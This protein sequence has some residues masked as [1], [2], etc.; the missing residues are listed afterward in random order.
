M[1][2]HTWYKNL[3]YGYEDAGGELPGGSLPE[4][5]YAGVTDALGEAPKVEIIHPVDLGGEQWLL[6]VEGNAAYAVRFEAPE[7]P[8]LSSWATSQA[9]VE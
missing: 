9:G 1:A 4:R 8:R 7:G 2:N 6:F 5:F 3:R